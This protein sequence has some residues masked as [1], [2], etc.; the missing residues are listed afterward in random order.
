VSS[1]IAVC[2]LYEGLR[3]GRLYVVSLFLQ[4]RLALVRGLK[5]MSSSQKTFSYLELTIEDCH[6]RP[7]PSKRFFL[8]GAPFRF[9]KGSRGWL[10]S[11]PFDL[12]SV[13]ILRLVVFLVVPY[14]S[15]RAYSIRFSRK[16]SGADSCFS[17]P[18]AADIRFFSLSCEL[19]TFPRVQTT[20]Q[21]Y[22][23]PPP[24]VFL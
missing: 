14:P 17:K 23:T 16:H 8:G 1:S 6:V 11:E 9:S 5:S 22:T 19:R 18:H 10:R 24:P 15:S 21:F 12:R 13:A 3:E 2:P 4:F 7:G 20:T